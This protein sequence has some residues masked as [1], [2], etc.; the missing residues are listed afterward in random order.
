MNVYYNAFCAGHSILP[1]GD[2]LMVGGDAQANNFANGTTYMIDGRNRVR[3]YHHSGFSKADDVK[4][5]AWDD[6][7][8]PMNNQRWYPTVATLGDGTAIIISG[9]TS[10]IDFDK[11]G[12]NV[13]PTYEYY[14]P[15]NNGVGWPK[16]L[17]ILTWAYPHSLYPVVFT[18]PSG[19]VFLFVSNKTVLIDPK[20]DE[21]INT[22]AD[23][24]PMDH[25]P[26][27]YP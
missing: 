11:L 8:T 27:I 23:M 19:N 7:P 4:T 18:L 10:N 26:W 15:K 21:I 13:N 6:T 20:T 2:V 16:D 1:N 12:D 14:P 9:T 22:V 25:A 3:V 5:G 17:S 24:P